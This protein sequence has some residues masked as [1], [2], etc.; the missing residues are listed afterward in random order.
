MLNFENLE[1]LQSIPTPFYYY[2]MDVLE[3]N[4]N[5]LREQSKL[6]KVKVHYA[7]KANNN[8]PI[9]KLLSSKGFGADCVSGPE[10]EQALATGFNPTD[11]VYAGVGKTDDEIIFAL[12]NNISCFN[13]ESMQELQIIDELAGRLNKI[14][15]VA[16]RIN[17]DYNA[18]THEKIT[19]GTRFNKFGIQ[20]PEI[21]SIIE[22][23]PKLKNIHFK[24]LHF[25]IGSQITDINVFAGLAEKVY[26]IQQMFIDSGFIPE[27]INLG[28]GF[29]VDY[30]D[31]D[32]NPIPDYK[33]YFE[34]LSNN[35]E[36]RPGQE[37]SI[38]P[39]RSVVANCGTLISKVL[40]IKPSVDG[41]FAILD[42]GMNDLMRPALYGASHPIQKINGIGKMRS[43][44]VA[45][46]VC[47]SSDIFGK[48]LQLP[49]LSRGDF[50]AIRTAGAYGESMASRYNLRKLPKAIY[51]NELPGQFHQ[52]NAPKMQAS[53]G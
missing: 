16:L 4:A 6:H 9:L 7:I 10:I 42:A 8:Q 35:L 3:A 28:G 33:A 48:N 29:G 34:A 21:N 36:R 52:F 5:L 44:H 27:S 19:T 30:E 49:E 46:P 2:N 47:E 39:G 25:H 15:P 40:F 45:G 14:A 18:R 53:N 24:G 43:Y 20:L 12:Q 41:E 32:S 11:I 38:E 26:T 13:C 31:P 17:P 22:I 1:I 23:L 50:L 37:I 51:S